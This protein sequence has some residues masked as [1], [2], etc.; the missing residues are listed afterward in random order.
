[1]KKLLFLALISL[2]G[3][4]MAAQDNRISNMDPLSSVA[5]IQDV[6]VHAGSSGGSDAGSSSLSYNGQGHSL[7]GSRSN[8]P[9]SMSGWQR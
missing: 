6:A 8:D 9:L 7:P 4:S 2:A 5:A 1:M 3:G